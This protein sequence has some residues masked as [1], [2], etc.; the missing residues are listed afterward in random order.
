MHQLAKRYADTVYE[1]ESAASQLKR[2]QAGNVDWQGQAGPKFQATCGDL[3]MRISATATRYEAASSALS[4]FANALDIAQ[5]EAA[6]AAL[7]DETHKPTSQR[8]CH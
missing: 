8:I 6:A 7:R 1:I 4:T 2:I 5:R 3:S